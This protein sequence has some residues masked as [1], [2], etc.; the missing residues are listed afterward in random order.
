MVVVGK[1]AT[2]DPQQGVFEREVD[3]DFKVEQ[4]EGQQVEHGVGWL[5]VFFKPVVGVG[6]WRG[7][8]A[9]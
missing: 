1:V 9:L 8:E 5:L 4:L 6:G 3:G 7:Q 2:L